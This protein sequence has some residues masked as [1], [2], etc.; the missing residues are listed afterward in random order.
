MTDKEQYDAIRDLEDR[1][2]DAGLEMVFDMPQYANV[3]D[4]YR[5]YEDVKKMFKD[6]GRQR[7]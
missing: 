1:F 4:A 5:D 6:E 2:Y 3:R 7:R